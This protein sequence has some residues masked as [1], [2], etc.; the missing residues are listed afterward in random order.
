MPDAPEIYGIYEGAIANV[1]DFGAFVSLEGFRNK[2]VEGFVHATQIAPGAKINVRDYVK[3]GAKVWVKVL[4]MVGDK[5]AL[6]MTAVDQKT[7]VDLRPGQK[8]A[9]ELDDDLRANPSRPKKKAFEDEDDHRPAKRMSSPERWE[10]TQLIHS[11]AI[12]ASERPD[13]DEETGE[14]AVFEDQENELEIELNDEEPAFLRGQTAQTTDLSPI[15]VVKNPDGSLQRAA[16]TQSALA[17]ER[18]EL[19]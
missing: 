14:L 17:K 8:R 12:A 15:K 6:S 11:G 3:R 1:M 10:L 7:G 9:A 5:L 18:R 16:L 2:R 4:S 19:R 13:V